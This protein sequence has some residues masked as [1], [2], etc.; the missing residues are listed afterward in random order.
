MHVD[1]MNEHLSAKLY[2]KSLQ[3]TER[4]HK[5]HSDCILIGAMFHAILEHMLSRD[6]KLKSAPAK[7]LCIYHPIKKQIEKMRLLGA[8]C[9]PG[10]LALAPKVEPID[11]GP[12]TRMDRQI[13]NN[14]EYFVGTCSSYQHV[15]QV[16]L[17][18]DAAQIVYSKLVHRNATDNY[19]CSVYRR[20]I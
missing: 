10:M 15:P 2:N 1:S 3:K 5:A 20:K 13:M 16:K 14:L 4:L 8:Q 9:Q 18:S 6:P 7:S 11:S 17:A 19:A 12:P